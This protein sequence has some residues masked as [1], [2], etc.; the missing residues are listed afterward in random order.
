MN[1]IRKLSSLV[2]V[3]FA[4]T[5]GLIRA[6][7]HILGFWIRFCAYVVVYSLSHV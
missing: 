3:C 7:A 5:W 2:L 4:S 6:P 1:K